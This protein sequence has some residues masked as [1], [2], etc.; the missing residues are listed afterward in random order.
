MDKED[1]KQ[2]FAKEFGING[3]ESGNYTYEDF[4]DVR[5]L[6][7]AM[8]QSGLGFAEIASLAEIAGDITDDED[9]KWVCESIDELKLDQLE[10]AIR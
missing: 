2:W 7:H 4:A 6:I 5:N 9:M 8:V 10:K 3:L 1:F